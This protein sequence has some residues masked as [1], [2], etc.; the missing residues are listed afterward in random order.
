MIILSTLAIAIIAVYAGNILLT[1]KRNTEMRPIKI[2][3]DDNRT[4]RRR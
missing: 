4:K 1:A 2:R 3:S